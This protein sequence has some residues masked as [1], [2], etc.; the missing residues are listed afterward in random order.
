MPTTSAPLGVAGRLPLLLLLLM[1]ATLCAATVV[2]ETACR[3]ER[4]INIKAGSA[5]V[6]ACSDYANERWNFVAPLRTSKAM[7]ASAD[8][9]TFRVAI[10]TKSEQKAAFDN[11]PA[12]A[13][14]DE[15]RA[16]CC[17]N[18]CATDTL[19]YNRALPY[20]PGRTFSEPV[21]VAIYCEG[22]NVFN[23]NCDVDVALDLAH[24]RTDAN[25]CDVAW[26]EGTVERSTGQR[27]CADGA[28]AAL[29]VVDSHCRCF[30]ACCGRLCR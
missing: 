22:G 28:L 21:Y 2:E 11:D 12:R 4:T 24:S 18:F 25:D 7:V 23:R 20:K 3:V 27:P 15:C 8:G 1:F 16:S 9:N 19:W 26:A 5:H 10:L 6:L 13:V 17:D 14:S 29:D 30:C